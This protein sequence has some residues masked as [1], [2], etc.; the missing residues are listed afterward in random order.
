MV[1][2]EI[3][4]INFR[5]DYIPLKLDPAYPSSVH[6]QQ[7]FIETYLHLLKRSSQLNG[8][9]SQRRLVVSAIVLIPADP[10]FTIVCKGKGDDLPPM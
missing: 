10:I 1:K 2:I 8:F 5:G 9:I 3:K 7:S 6:K 4:K